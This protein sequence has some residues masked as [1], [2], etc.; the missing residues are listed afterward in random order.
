MEINSSL[1]FQP[2]FLENHACEESGASV[3]TQAQAGGVRVRVSH[4]S[5][6]MMMAG[7]AA[8]FADENKWGK[9]APGSDEFLASPL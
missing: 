6:L 7:A 1:L 8:K 3:C 4:M 9:T 5:T 2:N